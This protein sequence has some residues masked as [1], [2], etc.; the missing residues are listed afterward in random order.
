VRDYEIHL[1]LGNNESERLKK[2]RVILNVSLRFSGDNGACHSDSLEDTVCYSKLLAFIDEKLKN[3][4][5]NLIE[6]AA[7]FLHDEISDYL[8][9]GEILVRVKVVKFP[10]A[11]K[12]PDGVSFICSDW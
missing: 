11:I 6:R 10:Y 9:N 2:Q 4:R 8:N 3:A 1:L 7:E 12:N 5:F